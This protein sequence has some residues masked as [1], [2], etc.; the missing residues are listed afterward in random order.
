MNKNIPYCF[1]P[2]PMLKRL[3][4]YFKGISHS[5]VSVFPFLK[6]NLKQSDF[7]Y[8]EFEYMSRCLATSAF[9]FVIFFGLSYFLLFSFRIKTPLL[10]A[11][12]ITLLLT[13]FTFFQQV[14][15][16][17]MLAGKKLKN[18]ERNLLA[19]LQSMMV[20]LNS[21]IP[22]FTIMV[23]ISEE[24][25]GEVSKEFKGAVKNINAG[26][27]QTDALEE[28][29]SKNSSDFSRR[30]IWQIANGMKA[31]SDIALVIEDIISALGDEQLLQIKQYGG[32]LNPL[33]MFYMLLAVIIPTLSVTFIT[34]LLSFISISAA[35]AKMVFWGFFAFIAFFQL[36]F[37]GVIKARRP[38]LV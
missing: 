9:N 10:T 26:I 30:T 11:L 2:K 22:L 36:M 20:Q 7:K 13:L 38:N 23:N 28:M 24:D 17:K 33:A 32:T 16:P 1:L 29:A 37:M 14:M 35:G 21:G 27:S 8:D 5:A 31:G 12:T 6:L 3:A 18:I 25:Y 15:Y 34:V 4:A 19:A